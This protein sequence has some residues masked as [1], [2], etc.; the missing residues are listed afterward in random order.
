MAINSSLAN[1][2]FAPD[3][4]KAISLT[5]AQLSSYTAPS[6]GIITFNMYGNTLEQNA[7]HVDVNGIM[8]F[9]GSSTSIDVVSSGT[10]FVAKNDVVKFTRYSNATVRTIY[11]IPFK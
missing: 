5:V 3:Y 7:V 4:S 6:N 9:I 2:S 8:V 1:I 10:I 11:F